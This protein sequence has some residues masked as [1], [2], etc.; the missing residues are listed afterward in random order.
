[1]SRLHCG[2]RQ[3]RNLVHDYA[4]TRRPA[5]MAPARG[6]LPQAAYPRGLRVT[7]VLNAQPGALGPPRQAPS[8][9][10]KTRRAGG[11]GQAGGA[12]KWADQ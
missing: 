8:S 6:A 11:A 5:T 12:K 1:M 9:A 10:C 2:R 3:L 4:A 7:R